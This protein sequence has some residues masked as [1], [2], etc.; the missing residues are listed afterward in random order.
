M[1][2]RW[3]CLHSI[4]G[5]TETGV[6]LLER[7]QC[8]RRGWFAGDARTIDGNDAQRPIPR[9]RRVEQLTALAEETAC[10]TLPFDL[11]SEESI[12]E[13]VEG[14]DLY[15][16]VDCSGFGGEIATPMETGI[17]FFD[18]VIAINAR[19]ALLVAQYAS[20][21]MIC[22]ARAAPSFPSASGRGE[23]RHRPNRIPY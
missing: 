23:S 1:A 13:A 6:C 8:R 7:Q 12:R 9:G 22:L 5:C 17:A 19:G 18:K 3:S 14:L 16:V 21:S 2:M 10:R 20:A 15:G 4:T 11:E